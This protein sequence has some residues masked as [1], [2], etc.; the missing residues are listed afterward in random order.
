MGLLRTHADFRRLWTGHTISQFGTQIGM[1]AIPLTAAV[2]LDATTFE[3]AALTAL[4]YLAFL[5]VGLPA[6]AWVDRVRRRPVLVAADLTR[7][8]LI[9]SIPAAAALDALTLPHLYVVVLAGGVA[10]VFFDVAY[11]SYLPALVG[12]AHLVEAN[13]RL[14]LSRSAGY[15][16]GPSLAGAAV[17]VLTAPVALVVDAAGFLWSA[18]W[19]RAVRRPEPAPAP[20]SRS[21]RSD[22]ADGLRLVARHPVLR[23]FTIYNTWTVLFISMEHALHVVFLLRVVG[24]DAAAIGALGTATGV[25]GLA[26]ALTVGP[27]VRRFGDA[28]VLI[29]AAVATHLGM[30]L[31]PL[32]TTG[33]GLVPY[34]AGAVLSAAGII[35][36][37]IVCVTLRQRI[38]PDHLL[39]RMNATMRFASWG[40]MPFGALL[41][42]ALGSAFGVRQA[43]LL[44]VLLA[45]LSLV[46]L[47][48]P[49][50]VAAVSRSDVTRERSS[51]PSR[52]TAL[53]VPESEHTRPP[54]T[55]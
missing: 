5:L 2:T 35:G 41:G 13:S 54:P 22:I 47:V 32:T 55:G 20:T 29:G 12:R 39:G 19:I 42:G 15:T 53:S 4:Q 40:P 11:Q 38:C 1:L 34:V 3:I 14:E 37:N 52:R 43:I 23:A 9:A 28:A 18:A 21:L 48:R 10:T 25:G 31:I 44:G 36:F 27:L 7:C 26:G 49:S 30:L 46:V 51:T 17:Q 50:L 8:G 24:L 6:G 33:A 16:A 45:A